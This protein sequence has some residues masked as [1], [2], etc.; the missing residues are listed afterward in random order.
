MKGYVSE[1]EGI[2]NIVGYIENVQ[3]EGD[4]LSFDLNYMKT[5][6]GKKYIECE[7]VG[8]DITFTDRTLKLTTD[9]SYVPGALLET[10][11]K[12]VHIIKF[13]I[14]NT[15]KNKISIHRSENK[16]NI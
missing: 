8:F 2:S 14:S 1:S 7:S 13:L 15:G 11:D 9:G 3:V 5:I 4:I 16:M 6:K 12:S 10:D